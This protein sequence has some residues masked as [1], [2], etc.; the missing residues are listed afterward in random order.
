ME[1]NT[2]LLFSS[3]A[4]IATITPGPAVLLISSQ[5]FNHGPLGAIYGILGNITGLFIMSLCSILG[6]SAIVL[7]STTIFYTIKFI[8]ALYLIYLGV[9]LWKTGFTFPQTTIDSHATRPRFFKLYGQGLFVALSNPKAIAFTTALFPQFIN[10]S[11]PLVLQF[12]LL[13]VTFMFFSFS[14]LFGYALISSSAK[15]RAKQSPVS[16][17]MGKIFGAAFIG[18]GLLLA[19][20]TK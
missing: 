9:K 1:F 3:I 13:I 4:L 16:L 7:Y 14:C 5:S 17:Y 18:S 11:Q 12:S 10:H 15:T 8:G 20:S 6:L 2:W 19:S